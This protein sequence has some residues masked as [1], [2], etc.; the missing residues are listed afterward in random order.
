MVYARTANTKATV[1]FA[2]PYPQTHAAARAT[3]ECQHQRFSCDHR[4][5]PHA[6]RAIFRKWWLFQEVPR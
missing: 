5:L 3:S 6:A 4:A 1:A 2:K